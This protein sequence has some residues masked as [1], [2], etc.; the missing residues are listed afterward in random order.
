MHS[1]DNFNRFFY[2]NFQKELQINP[3]KQMNNNKKTPNPTKLG[4][5]NSFSRDQGI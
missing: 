5:E 1:A 2:Q 3:N 4:T